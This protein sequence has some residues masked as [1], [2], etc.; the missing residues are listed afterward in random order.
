MPTKTDYD[1]DFVEWTA[2]TAGL[3]REGRFAEVDLEHLAE[4]IE[5]LGK[6]EAREVRS[7]LRRMLVQLIKLRIQPQHERDSWRH[8]VIDAHIEIDGRLEDSPSL[9]G[10]LEENLEK[11]YCKAV[12]HALRETNLAG[13]AQELD[14]PPTCPYSLDHL[15]TAE[16]DALHPL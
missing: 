14:I 2:R 1:A 5:D 13:R 11:I 15:L 7:H 16:L 9:R 4:E 12:T 6:R 3:L 8:S 10:H